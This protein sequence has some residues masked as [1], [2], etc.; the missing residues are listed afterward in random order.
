MSDWDCRE[1]SDSMATDAKGALLVEQ[2]PSISEESL[3][4][5]VQKSEKLFPVLIWLLGN[6]SAAVTKMVH[7]DQIGPREIAV[8]NAYLRLACF[9]AECCAKC[10]KK[11]EHLAG[12]KTNLIAID[13]KDE[14]VAEFH[15]ICTNQKKKKYKKDVTYENGDCSSWGPSM[16]AHQLYMNIAIRMSHSESKHILKLCMMAFSNKVFKI[17]DHL[18]MISQR[19]GIPDIPHHFDERKYDVKTTTV[20]FPNWP[21]YD[22]GHGLVAKKS[23]STGA[24]FAPNGIPWAFPRS[25]LPLQHRVVTPSVVLRAQAAIKSM[26]GPNRSWLGNDTRQIIYEPQGMH[27]GLL[28]ECSS[29][30]AADCMNLSSWLT[31]QTLSHCDMK[32]YG[33]VTSD[34]YNRM[35]TYHLSEDSRFKVLK[36][37]VA[38]DVWCKG[39]MG[40]KKN[41]V[42]SSCVERIQELGSIFRT[43]EG[44]YEPDIKQRVSFVDVGN[45]L[46][47]YNSALR[48]LTTSVEYVRKCQSLVGA[49]WVMILNMHLSM[50]QMDTLPLFNSLG[51]LIYKLP[52]ELGGQVRPNPFRHS[53]TTT[54]VAVAE[55]YSDP[56]PK[57]LSSLD[58]QKAMAR[59]L[60][61]TNRTVELT[62]EDASRPDLSMFPSVSRSGLT[63]LCQKPDKVKRLMTE[64]IESVPDHLFL[65]L[66]MPGQSRMLL[67]ALLSCVQRESINSHRETPVLWNMVQ[68]QT[69]L[70]ATVYACLSPFMKMAVESMPDVRLSDTGTPMISRRQILSLALTYSRW[71][72]DV[73]VFDGPSITADVYLNN[74][75]DSITLPALHY[76][77]LADIW[78]SFEEQVSICGTD[79][80]PLT[81]VPINRF[82]GQ[83]RAVDTYSDPTF[84]NALIQEYRDLN[85]PKVF[86]GTTDVKPFLYIAQESVLRHKAAKLSEMRATF[87]MVMSTDDFYKSLPVKLFLSNAIEGAQIN[88]ITL[89]EPSTLYLK[90]QF[91]DLDSEWFSMF[92]ESCNLDAG[93]DDLVS[94]IRPDPAEQRNMEH[95]F[96]FPR[97]IDISPLVEAWVH[98]SSS[99]EHRQAT[100]LLQ[101]LYLRQQEMCPAMVRCPFVVKTSSRLVY[102]SSCR[103]LKNTHDNGVWY[104]VF[105]SETRQVSYVNFRFKSTHTQ[106]WEH[107]C[108]RYTDEELHDVDLDATDNDPTYLAMHEIRGGMIEVRLQEHFRSLLL[109]Q[110]TDDA[111]FSFTH[112]LGSAPNSSDFVVHIEKTNPSRQDLDRLD[113]TLEQIKSLQ[114]SFV[115][116]IKSIE[117]QPR[118]ATVESYPYMDDDS[119]YDPD[120]PDLL[121]DDGLFSSLEDMLMGIKTQEVEHTEDE[122]EV[123][124]N[125]SRSSQSSSR[126]LLIMETMTKFKDVTPGVFSSWTNETVI[127][128]IRLPYKLPDNKY[129]TISDLVADAESFLDHHELLIV[130]DMLRHACKH[131]INQATR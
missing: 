42:K 104:D 112:Y 108:I 114:P 65:P 25:K 126:S 14:I 69:P 9:F 55:N 41:E 47:F 6:N 30:Y 40:I 54:F 91:I 62:P 111:A 117:G 44:S 120:G 51:A 68:P 48:C 125:I 129:R 78:K 101:E 38:T 49:G 46:D 39:G 37:A 115:D 107:R 36:T 109:T 67:S 131:R 89:D 53:V 5:N 75:M 66:T 35:M 60:S 93:S 82:T 127:T 64:F 27:M 11:S 34:D 4:K 85:R 77:R 103:P 94:S 106:M 61:F 59:M 105:K 13:N 45:E 88:T 26:S 20:G 7:K 130:K 33:F 95:N 100:R 58:L 119:L 15:N 52:L 43:D 1:Y 92:L 21:W 128:S 74:K 80:N 19:S 23:V 86:G 122:A 121:E 90:H 8:M 29:V 3:K 110:S 31:E 63:V 98:P 10:I 76:G 83:H 22:V 17:P 12:L 123:V 71:M 57:L 18:Y 32:V 102:P 56:S 87:K 72:P 79:D 116:M 84:L 81:V 118:M 2:P 50:L 97:S 73:D 70:D 24:L 124:S 96:I 113:T 99:M 28:G 16:M